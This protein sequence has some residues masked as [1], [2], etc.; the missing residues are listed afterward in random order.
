M[1]MLL[2]APPGPPPRPGLVWRE[3][4]SRWVCPEEGCESRHDHNTDRT[5]ISG[6][7]TGQEKWERPKEAVDEKGVLRRETKTNQLIPPAWTNVW[8]NSRK[9]ADL[10]AI[11][12]DSQGRTVRIP[13]ERFV[14]RR[15]QEKYKRAR[16]FRR[17]LPA[18]RKKIREDF[19]HSEEAKVLTLIDLTG[20]RVGGQGQDVYGATTLQSQHVTVR[21]SDIHFDFVGKHGQQQRK[22]IKSGKLAR[23]IRQRKREVGDEDRLFNTTDAKV[24]QYF[25]RSGLDEFS[26]KDFRTVQGTELARRSVKESPVPQSEA[27]FKQLKRR[28]G[29]TV[30]RW[31]GNKPAVALGSYIDPTVFRPIERELGLVKAQR[32]WEPMF[33]LMLEDYSYVR[34]DWDG[35]L[36][37]EELVD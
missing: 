29:E 12:L 18:L 25:R 23:I 2:K 11:G 5:I 8:I 37:T 36:L 27:E 13:S 19:D 35:Q 34:G 9:R 31:L 33:N 17:S 16:A 20:F 4:T 1:T 15:A 7:K 26:P 24:R 10:Q 21:G 6:P 32:Q 14:K 22:S 3:K 28:V 30:S